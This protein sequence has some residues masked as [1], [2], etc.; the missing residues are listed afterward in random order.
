MKSRD[1]I[2][3]AIAEQS[4]IM[5]NGLLTLLKRSQTIHIQ[6]VELFSQES[7]QDLMHTQ[8]PDILIINPHF[9]N[10]FDVIRFRNDNKGKHIIIIAFVCMLLETEKLTGY[11]E[12][13][14]VL[15][16][17]SN[18]YNK[19]NLLLKH[20]PSDDMEFQEQG[21]LSSREKDIVIG[22]VHGLTNKEIADRLFISVNTVITHRRNISRKLQIHSPAGLT[23][24]AIINK[25]VEMNELK[26]Q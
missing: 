16:S 12:K 25:L 22:V 15:D 3:V 5:R 1:F 9:M 14:S 13:I 11:D 10:F 17:A 8:P 20:Q 23:I 4:D 24:Y 2:R 18:I 6:P 7:L 26:K 21:N 19:I